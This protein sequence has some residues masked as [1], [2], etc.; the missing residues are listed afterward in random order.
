EEP[1]AGAEA[2]RRFV[3][4]YDS[5]PGGTG[6]LHDL[7]RSPEA[8][9]DVF[10]LAR[11]T[12]TACVCNEDPEKDGCY[13][14]LYAYRNSYGMETT[15][16]DTAVTLLTEI[17]EAG[18]RFEPV[19]TI[20]DIMVNPL[21]ESELEVRFIEAL[22][23]SEAAGH[24][25]TVRPEVVNGKPGY[26]LCVGDQCYTVEPQVELG[27]E[28]GVHYASRADFLIRSARESREFR[29]IAVFLDGFQYHKESVTD[30]TCKRLA[31]V[32]SNAYFQWSINWQDVEAQFSNADV[33][34]INFFT[35]KNHAQMSALQQQ[36]TDR[37]GVADLAR[38]HLRNSFDQLIHYLAK[39][40]QE[41][42]RHA[43]FVRALG[44]FDQ[45]QMRD[46]QVVEHF[47]DRFRENA[48]TAFSAIADDLI[49]DP[50]VGGFG[51]DQE[52]ETVSLQCALPLRAIQE[53]DS[54]AMIVLLSMDLSKRGTD[55]TFRPIWAGFFHAINLLQFLPAVQFGTI[56]GIR[57]GAY[58]PIE[59]RFGQMALGKPTLEQKPTA[60][61][62]LEYVE[63]SLRNGLLRLLEH[64]TPMPEV[65]F[66]LQDGNGEIVAEAELA[67]EAPKLAVLTA[68]QETGKTSFEQLGWKVVCASGDETW[69]EAVLAILSEVMD[70]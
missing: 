23:R 34:A 70:E 4:L 1:I 20:G 64:G 41:R 24:H 52:A 28:S 15:S 29:P 22:K 36:L 17:L 53:Q 37:L 10:R 12:M 45:Q 38:I 11:D 47:L 51:W 43:A 63:E 49:E 6:Y 68:D 69:Q 55:E 54:R 18:D 8:L 13:R 2:K 67:W 14:C 26:F 21:H 3:M 5:V 62:E 48:C 30:D 46:A 33:Q 42:W 56:E 57:S 9:L 32:Q 27:R 61:V 66:E 16:R 44:W 25:L 35:E 65:G 31:L 58:E 7:M 50:A 19:D 60:P 40:D 39:P 59:F